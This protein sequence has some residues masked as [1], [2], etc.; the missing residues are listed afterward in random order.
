MKLLKWVNNF[1]F[2]TTERNGG[3]LRSPAPY[4]KIRRQCLERGIIW[5]DPDF[6]PSYKLL[7]RSKKSSYP[8][9]WLR[10]HVSVSI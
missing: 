3:T 10:P 8:V 9:V 5:E 1:R 6:V 2:W 7:Q 4:V